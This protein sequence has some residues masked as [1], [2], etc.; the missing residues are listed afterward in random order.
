MNIH[1]D[2]NLEDSFSLMRLES[3]KSFSVFASSAALEEEYT[4]SSIAISSQVAQRPA[5]YVTA[6]SGEDDFLIRYL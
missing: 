4:S 2:T 3:V 5:F 1:M 6:A